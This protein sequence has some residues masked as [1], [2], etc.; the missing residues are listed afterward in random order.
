MIGR[1]QRQCTQRP[2]IKEDED[3]GI[4]EEELISSQAKNHIFGLNVFGMYG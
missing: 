1:T 2:R 4:F 3:V